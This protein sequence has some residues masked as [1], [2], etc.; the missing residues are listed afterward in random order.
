M[1][2]K[3]SRKYIVACVPLN[4]SPEKYELAFS[5]SSIWEYLQLNFFE[6]F[7]I[8]LYTPLFF[9]SMVGCTRQVKVV[10]IELEVSLLPIISKY[11]SELKSLHNA[12]KLWLQM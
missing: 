5:K 12:L 9:S 8:F 3:L 6:L 11:E 1:V 4:Y 2:M 10:I 7:D